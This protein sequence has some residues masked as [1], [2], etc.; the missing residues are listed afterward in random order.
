MTL[1]HCNEMDFLEE[2]WNKNKHKFE[3]RLS[4]GGVSYINAV[5]KAEK[6]LYPVFHIISKSRKNKITEAALAIRKE[7]ESIFK[8]LGIYENKEM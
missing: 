5:F 1:E 8:E 4:S 6:A 7:I 2:Y 3:D